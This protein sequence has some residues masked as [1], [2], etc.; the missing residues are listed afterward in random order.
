MQ[1][2]ICLASFIQRLSKNNIRD[3]ISFIKIMSPTLIISLGM[4][5]DHNRVW[6]PFHV[7]TATQCG[8]VEPLTIYHLLSIMCR[9]TQSQEIL[10]LSF[11]SDILS[12]ILMHSCEPDLQDPLLHVPLTCIRMC[13]GR[14]GVHAG[15]GRPTADR[16]CLTSSRWL[17]RGSPPRGPGNSWWWSWTAGASP[18]APQ[19]DGKEQSRRG[20][21]WAA[22]LW[23]TQRRG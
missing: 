8:T 18:P 15:T 17:S 13:L 4:I 19:L 6:N 10:K 1:S 12:W 22:H 23:T 3:F 5:N 11:C 2:H 9:H 14:R 7:L 21:K 16:G 20:V